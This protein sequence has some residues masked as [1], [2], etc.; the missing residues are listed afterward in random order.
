MSLNNRN[1]RVDRKLQVNVTNGG[2]RLQRFY[3]DKV[4]TE[5]LWK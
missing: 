2:N 5:L 1:S 4:S 3:M